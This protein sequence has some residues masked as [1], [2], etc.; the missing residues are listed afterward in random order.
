MPPPSAAAHRLQWRS[1]P[2]EEACCLGDTAFQAAEGTPTTRQ[3]CPRGA[4]EDRRL[5]ETGRALLPVVG[6]GK[7]V[8]PRVWEY[9]HARLTCT[10]AACTGLVQWQ[11]F[12]PNASGFVPSRW[13]R[14]VCKIPLLLLALSETNTIS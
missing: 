6:H 1:R 12:Q 11:G 13:L 5:L 14:V 10:R 9:G 8:M 3:R 2:W 7:Q 4:W